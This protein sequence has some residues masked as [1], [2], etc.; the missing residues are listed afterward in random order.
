MA[1]IIFPSENDIGGGA[2]GRSGSE[3]NMAKLRD[4][5]AMP[6]WVESGLT[7]GPASRVEGSDPVQIAINLGVA[8]ISGYRLEIDDQQFPIELSGGA[9]FYRIWLQLTFDGNSKVDG[10]QFVV[11]RNSLT[12]PTDAIILW[13]IRLNSSNVVAASYDRRARSA[14]NHAGESSAHETGAGDAV[15]LGAR[16]VAIN[17]S[18]SSTLIA[19][20]GIQH[21]STPSAGLYFIANF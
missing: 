19:N 2:L 13:E 15:V 10:Y 17:G 20:H 14:C 3:A 1:D 16:P 6:G 18:A 8:V 12:I 5:S 4:L 7:E 21:P 9:G 11:T